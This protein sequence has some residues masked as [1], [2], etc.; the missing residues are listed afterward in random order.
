MLFLTLVLHGTEEELHYSFSLGELLS[1][2]SHNRIH[3]NKQGRV[4]V[5]VA[6]LKENVVFTNARFPACR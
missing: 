4:A 3:S 5:T 2:T 6:K 1:S